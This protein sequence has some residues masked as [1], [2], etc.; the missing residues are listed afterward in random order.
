MKRREKRS[1][2]QVLVEDPCRDCG[3]LVWRVKSKLGRRCRTCSSR[4]LIKPLVGLKGSNNHNWKG[5][6]TPEIQK[7]Y[8]SSEWK[9]LRTKVFKRD[10]YTCQDCNQRGGK[11]EANHIKA[12]WKYP[13]LRLVMSNIETLCKKCHDKKKWMVYLP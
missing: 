8:S 1:H 9:E 6:R 11:L 12:R 4:I 5:G 3:K 10:D 7:F 2:R 13:K